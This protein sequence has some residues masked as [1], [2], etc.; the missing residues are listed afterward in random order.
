MLVSM[1]VQAI[2]RLICLPLLI[3][4]AVSTVSGYFLI[5]YLRK[6]KAGQTERDDGPKSHLKKSGTP[7]MGGLMILL[8]FVV[9]GV[10]MARRAPEV[11]PVL[12]LTV[13]FGA[14]GFVDDYIKVV[15]KRSMGLK[16]WQKLLLQI[17]IA[18][19]FTCYIRFIQHIPLAM[20]V[21]FAVV[22]GLMPDI[23]I[24]T[25][26]CSTEVSGRGVI[27]SIMLHGKAMREL[28]LR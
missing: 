11:I 5:P 22:K 6:I 27:L 28:S 20:K 12:I 23:P 10:I 17:A 8:C 26:F 9:S 15:L 25:I 1:D 24:S 18:M 21:P 16:A 14:V 19:I 13:G 3:A 2:C 4:F 7:N